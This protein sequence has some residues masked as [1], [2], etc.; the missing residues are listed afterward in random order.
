MLPANPLGKNPC[1]TLVASGG[2]RQSLA[3]L[4]LRM[5]P[6]I[7]SLL[8]S[9]LCLCLYGHLSKY[10]YSYEDIGYIGLRVRPV[11]TCLNICKDTTARQGRIHGFYVVV[12]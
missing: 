4:S 1:L 7:Q 5:H 8:L 3:F 6:Y 2:Y 11:L 10:P 9:S 12:N